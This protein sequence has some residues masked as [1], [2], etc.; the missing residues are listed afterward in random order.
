LRAG[1]NAVEGHKASKNGNALAI[2]EDLPDMIARGPENMTAAEKDLLKWLG[3]F[4]RKPTP[5]RF[6]MRISALEQKL[7]TTGEPLSFH[8]SGCPAACGNHQA[9]ELIERPAEVAA[10]S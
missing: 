7:G 6:M 10:A 1:T 4:F 2:R 9:A 5:G 3:V 8:W